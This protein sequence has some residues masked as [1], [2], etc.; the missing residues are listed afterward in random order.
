MDL[1]PNASK[2]SLC[3]FVTS[4]SLHLPP[5]H[6]IFS[7]YSVFSTSGTHILPARPF[8]FRRLMSANLNLS[9]RKFTRSPP[10]AES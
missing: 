3:A 7:F 9:D 4:F 1:D 6:E 5:M 8:S 10:W 2:M